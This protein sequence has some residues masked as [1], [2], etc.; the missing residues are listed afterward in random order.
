MN[1]NAHYVYENK[2]YRKA[3]N[4]NVGPAG[5]VFGGKLC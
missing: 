2:I 5:N 3:S 4:L 1:K